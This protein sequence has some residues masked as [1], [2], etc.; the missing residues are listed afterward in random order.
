M[1][2]FLYNFKKNSEL[3]LKFPRNLIIIKF[4]EIFF[5]NVYDFIIIVP[6]FFFNWLNI[7]FWNV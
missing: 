7:F 1:L 4:A 2:F 6:V 5:Y 3:E